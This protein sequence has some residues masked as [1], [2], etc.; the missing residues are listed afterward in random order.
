MNGWQGCGG[1]SDTGGEGRVNHPI[2]LDTTM[3]RMDN[4]A[5]II[6]LLREVHLIVFKEMERLNLRIVEL[7]N[8]NRYHADRASSASTATPGPRPPKLSEMMNER[9]VAEHI[10]MSLG[11]LRRWRLFRTGP[12]FVKIGRAVRYKRTDVEA[13][14]DSRPGSY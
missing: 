13:W 7:E 10:N 5:R 2:L 9:Q 8:Q 11:A 4:Q 12:K 14:L 1:R 6:E 3:V